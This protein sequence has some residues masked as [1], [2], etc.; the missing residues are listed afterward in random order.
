MG[1]ASSGSTESKNRG[2]MCYEYVHVK[3][4]TFAGKRYHGNNTK[5]DVAPALG[6]SEEANSTTLSKLA[7]PRG[8]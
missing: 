3:D 2:S 6:I 5:N 1:C 7:F 4:P 8:K